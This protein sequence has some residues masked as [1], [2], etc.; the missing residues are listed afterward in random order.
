MGFGTVAQ[1][2]VGWSSDMCTLVEAAD[3][4]SNDLRFKE[5]SQ[6]SHRLAG[7]PFPPVWPAAVR[8]LKLSDTVPP[9]LSSKEQK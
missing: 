6:E 3:F 1:G 4:K 2:C 5:S 8:M 9:L 7:F